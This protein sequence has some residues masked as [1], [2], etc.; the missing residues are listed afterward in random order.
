M[1]YMDSVLPQLR[2]WQVEPPAANLRA[3]LVV[4]YGLANQWIVPPTR[5]EES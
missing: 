5:T 4:R 2:L 3:D 1:P